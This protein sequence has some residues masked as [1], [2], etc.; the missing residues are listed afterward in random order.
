M[1]ETIME[2]LYAMMFVVSMGL[3]VILT[4]DSHD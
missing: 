1:E 3:I 2:L 4:A